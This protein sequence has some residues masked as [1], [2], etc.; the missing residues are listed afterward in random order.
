MAT[1]IMT[2]TASYPL[3]ALL[4]TRLSDA[5]DPR[6]VVTSAGVL[7]VVLGLILV[8]RTAWLARLDDPT[9]TS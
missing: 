9:D 1:R 8:S 3:G 5:T 2:F 6:L 7:I 4:Q